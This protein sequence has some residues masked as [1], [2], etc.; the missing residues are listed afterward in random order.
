M[1]CSPAGELDEDSLLKKLPGTQR[2]NHGLMRLYP[3]AVAQ[4]R[5]PADDFVFEGHPDS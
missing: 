4:L 3:I 2:R 1:R 5:D